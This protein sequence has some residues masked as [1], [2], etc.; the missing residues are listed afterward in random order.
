VSLVLMHAFSTLYTHGLCILSDY[1]AVY[2]FFI[3][4]IIVI[5]RLLFLLNLEHNCVGSN[6]MWR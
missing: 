6:V 4:I 3:I 5:N 2:K 1:M